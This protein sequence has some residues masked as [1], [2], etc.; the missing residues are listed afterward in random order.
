VVFSKTYENLTFI[1]FWWFA[2]DFIE[3]NSRQKVIH[4]LFRICRWDS[5]HLATMLISGYLNKT[6]GCSDLI[7][8]PNLGELTT[9]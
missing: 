5:E 9:D 6:F 4:R 1:R 7:F 8:P 2:V 3:E